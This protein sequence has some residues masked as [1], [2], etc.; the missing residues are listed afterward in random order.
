[1]VDGEDLEADEVG[2]V[3]LWSGHCGCL[4]VD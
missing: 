2:N 3:D 4:S 1:L